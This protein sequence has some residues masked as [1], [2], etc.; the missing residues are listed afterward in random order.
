M[1]YIRKTV[2]EYD[3]EGDYGQGFEVVTCESTWKDAKAQIKI[4]RA[5]E[6]GVAFRIKHHRVKKVENEH[7]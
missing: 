1:P 7:V 6:P 2:D 4:Y 5:S 3:I